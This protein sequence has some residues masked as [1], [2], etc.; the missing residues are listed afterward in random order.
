MYPG[1][2]YHR[3]SCFQRLRSAET[4]E[5]PTSWHVRGRHCHA[6]L[7][8][9]MFHVVRGYLGAMALVSVAR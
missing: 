6:R 9:G 7:E 2:L 8:S 5:K 3:E 4:L 1:I